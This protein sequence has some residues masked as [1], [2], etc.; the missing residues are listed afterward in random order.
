MAFPDVN[1][2][3][4]T[5]QSRLASFKVSESKPRRRTSVS[6]KK[7]LKT[8]E[9]WPHDFLSPEALAAAGFY[10][11]PLVEGDDNVKCF[12]CAKMLAGWEEGD[13]PIDEHLKHSGT[14]GWAVAL[15]L[16]M[17]TG[18]EELLQEDPMSER[19]LE[20]RMDTF[21]ELW[22]HD[23]KKGWVSK[24][25]QM[26]AAGW[27]YTPTEGSD[28]LA[29]CAYCSLG[30][31]GWEPKDKPIVEHRKR[32]PDCPFF[33]LVDEHKSGKEKAATKSKSV[34]SSRVS[35]LSIQSNLTSNS[36]APSFVEEAAEDDDSMMTSVTNATSR[37]GAKKS[38]GTKAITAKTRKPRAKKQDAEEVIALEPENDDNENK[39][40][41]AM[42]NSG[43][44][45]AS[46]QM[47]GDSTA[48]AEQPP[49]AKRRTIRTRASMAVENNATILV[50]EKPAEEPAAE[51]ST[52][53]RKT[54]RPSRGSRKIS[55]GSITAEPESTPHDDEIDRALVADLERPITDDEDHPSEQESSAPIVRRVSRAMGKASSRGRPGARKT[56]ASVV[57]NNDSC[58]FESQLVEFDE[59]SIDKELA[60]L[61]I[62]EELKVPRQ[63]KV[64]RIKQ[65]RKPSAKQQA[66][67]R[68]AE[69]AA[70]APTVDA[71]AMVLDMQ[72][73]K[74]PQSPEPGPKP[75]KAGKRKPRKVQ[76]RGTR[77]S[78]TS[79]NAAAGSYIPQDDS[80]VQISQDCHSENDTDASM[81]S[82]S[83]VIRGGK[84]RRGS[85]LRK[86]R[87]GKKAATC[88]IEDII[89]K[90][91]E[92]APPAKQSEKSKK[93][94][95]VMIQ[96]MDAD[97]G[98][99][100]FEDAVDSET[101]RADRQFKA[102]SR[103]EEGKGKVLQ[104][105]SIEP[106]PYTSTPSSLSVPFA[107]RLISSARNSPQPPS[108][109]RGPQEPHISLS[110]QS[111]DAENHPPSL[112][113]SLVR[114]SLNL[115]DITTAK[116]TVQVPLASTPTGSPSKRNVINGLQTSQPWTALNLDTMFERSPL[117]ESE[118]KNSDP[119]YLAFN[120]ILE[121]AR[122][123]HMTSPEKKMTVEEW[124]AHNAE[125]AA[126]KLKEDCERMVGVFEEAGQ[127]AMRSVEGIMCHDDDQ[128]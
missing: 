15:A 103:K 59:S 14:C 120:E 112:R 58:I 123:G 75:Q 28:D 128:A 16:Q 71:D 93:G 105:L 55:A 99:A 48:F 27:Y 89:H 43:K 12:L 65:A 20:A 39:V 97:E 86:G 60:A 81:A 95:E 30:L 47:N 18:Y 45:R 78:S 57:S 115:H 37:A 69:K 72:D 25:K 85:A 106:A 34:R 94:K 21:G 61:E 68:R 121:R 63:T 26:A 51:A 98:P 2:H 35:I 126:G 22:P 32:S 17:K 107:S 44:K 6:S 82:Q 111:S 102:E 64:A 10:Y 62:E 49:P 87:G 109:P 4:H 118:V 113:P 76:V 36:D 33:R 96:N 52:A 88:N 41:E 100:I 53:L 104:E 1:N 8:V 31:D 108:T 117:K 77:A 23:G 3:Y 119:G 7:K 67:A 114:N 11:A 5:L 101:D 9:G 92:V 125:L 13:V 42:V 84:P 29:T 70:E 124:I 24:S 50:L 73:N 110:P 66:A 90:D 91:V 80:T 127:R 116:H 54:G 79:L 19:M 56:R 46:D 122:I 40:E 83:T 38:K 74:Q